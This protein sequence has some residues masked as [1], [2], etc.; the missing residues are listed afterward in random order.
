MHPYLRAY[1]AGVALPTMVV[2]LVVVGLAFFHPTGHPFHVEDVLIFPIGLVPNAWGLWNMFYVWLRRHREVSA[3]LFGAGLVLVLGPMALG[4]QLA[5]GK[6]L[7]T[8]AVVA[9]G[10]PATIGL[11]YLAWKHFVARLNDV[12]GIG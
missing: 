10:L 4:I 6:M 5:L 7:W 3:G 1:L 8:P 9:V 2:P 12:L 11:Y